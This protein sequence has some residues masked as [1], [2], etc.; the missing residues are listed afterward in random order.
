MSIN[1]YRNATLLSSE[2][3]I[4][5]IVN[6]KKSLIRFGDGELLSMKGKSISYQ[7]Q[8]LNLSLELKSIEQMYLREKVDCNFI[9]CMPN[10]FLK[11][12]GMELLKRREWISSWSFFRYY[13]K[14]NLDKSVEYGDSFIFSKRYRER[15]KEIWEKKENIIF[16]HNK[17]NYADDFEKLTGKK[18]VFISVPEK[19]AYASID[20]IVNN[21]KNEINKLKNLEKSMVLISAGP[22][23]KAVIFRLINEEIQIIDTGHCWDDPLELRE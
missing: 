23:A 18:V 3:T 9:L 14:N 4:E 22:C 11:C 17:K 12:S 16:V 20:H 1:C 19:N 7:E 5:K 6:S 15:Y 2:K 8:N 10:E 13:F 21:I